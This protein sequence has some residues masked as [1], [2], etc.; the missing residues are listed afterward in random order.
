MKRHL[1]VITA[2][3]LYTGC[4]TGYKAQTIVVDATKTMPRYTIKVHET[5]LDMQNAY[6]LY[7]VNSSKQQ[8]RWPVVNRE[9]VNGFFSYIDDTI[10]CYAPFPQETIEHEKLHL[11]AKYRLIDTKHPHFRVD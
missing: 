8:R 10:H 11:M 3:I 2:L 6:A 4:A 9:R 1:I 7:N 5:K